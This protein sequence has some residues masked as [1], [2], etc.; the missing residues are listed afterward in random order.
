MNCKWVS[1]NDKNIKCDRVGDSSGYCIFHKKNKSKREN[2][3]FYAYIKK[4]KIYDFTG[5]YFEDEFNI[6]KIIKYEYEKLKFNEVIFTNRVIFDDYL[7]KSSVEFSN[8]QFEGYTSFNKTT[9][10]KNCTFFKT[11][12]NEKYIN[13]M[14][15]ENANFN[16]QKLIIEKCDSFPRLDGVIFSP[17]TKFILK[18]THYNMENALCGKNNYRIARIQGKQIEDVENIGY[19]YYNERNYA[20]KFL[21]DEK[22]KGY[23]EYLSTKVFDFLSKHVLGYGEKPLKLLLISIGVVSIF[24]LIYM[25]I[26]IKSLDYG[27]IKI[28]LH[29]NP[30]SFFQFIQ[31]YI[32][33]WY[34]SIITF[35]TVGYGDVVVIGLF[36]KIVVCMEVFL[37]VTI[38]AMW[39]SILLTRMIR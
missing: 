2:V 34:F 24:A 8:T 35:C 18:E 7:F 17:Y 31:Y 28:N 5:F 38:N 27:L 4:G 22:Y 39:T 33:A 14:I 26:G 36:G 6:S 10:L 21:K 29:K 37:G 32:E 25:F 16:G 19:Y 15:F 13:E 23:K 9:F 11:I 1:Q 30:Y 12:F 20:S 3:L